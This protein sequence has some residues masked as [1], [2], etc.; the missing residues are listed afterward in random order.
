MI[1]VGLAGG[2]RRRPP[3]RRA[4]TSTARS[5]AWELPETGTSAATSTGRSTTSLRPVRGCVRPTRGEWDDVP[6]AQAAAVAFTLLTALALFAARPAAATRARRGRRS[7]SR[8][9]SPGSPTRSRSTRS[10]RASTTRWSGAAG[11]LLAA[12]VLLAAGRGALGALAGLTKFGPLALTPLLRRRRRASGDRRRPRCSRRRS[13]SLAALVDPPAA[14]RRRL[15]RALRPLARL[16]G[17]PRTR[18]SASGARRPRWTSCRRRPRSSP[19]LFGAA[20]SLRPPQPHA[21][22]G[23]R[24]RRRGADRGPGDGE[25]LALSLRGLVR[26]PRPG[27]PLRS[28]EGMRR[29]FDLLDSAVSTNG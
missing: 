1:D 11:R 19:S 2:D 15:P 23:L 8:S 17:L 14:P 12:G 20:L 16:P 9:P 4:M 28:P 18:R 5:P 29:I 21:R 22:P 27:R 3:D 7:G 26:A 10:A 25:P 6:A 24:A 13:S